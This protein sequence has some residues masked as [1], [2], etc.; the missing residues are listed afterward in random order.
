[1][2]ARIYQAYIYGDKFEVCPLWTDSP[3]EVIGIHCNI[4]LRHIS[5]VKLSLTA[6]TR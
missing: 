6:N 5:L 2:M 1:M 3:I 4:V